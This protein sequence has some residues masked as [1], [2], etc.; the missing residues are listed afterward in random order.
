[1]EVQNIWEQEDEMM[2]SKAYQQ[3]MDSYLASRHR[4]H[5]EIIDKAFNF[6]KEPTKASADSL[7]NHTSCTPSLWRE[8]PAKR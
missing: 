6:A 4:K 8:L 2:V 3:L 7:A 5:T 1:M